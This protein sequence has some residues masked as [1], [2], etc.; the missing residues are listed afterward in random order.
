M[1]CMEEER[2]KA[3]VVFASTYEAAVNHLTLEQMGELFVKLGRYSLE[4]EAVH[5]E[6]PMVD[7]IL[8]MTIPNMD[9]AEERHLRAIENG[10]K[11][12]DFG[13]RGGRPRKGETREEYD[14]RRMERASAIENPQKPLNIDIDKDIDINKDNNTDIDKEI[15]ID[16]NRYK[17][18]NNNINKNTND[19]VN[20]NRVITNTLSSFENHKPEREET[21]QGEEPR[22]AASPQHQSPLDNTNK[23]ESETK[24]GAD[25]QLNTN[26]KPQSDF[27]RSISLDDDDDGV[28]P[29]PPDERYMNYVG[30][31]QDIVRYDAEPD[32]DAMTDEEIM[33]S[34]I[35][36]IDMAI[37][38]ERHEG[39][40]Q[41]YRDYLHRAKKMYMHQFR[42]SED[43]AKNEIKR[44]YRIRESALNP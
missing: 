40:T 1:V 41:R 42:C 23:E 39:I 29:C 17:E 36:T 16:N 37:E 21:H 3:F 25:P 44:R 13:N 4:G 6:T 8:K 7:V 43:E 14:A 19:I 33:Q 9:A 30:S 26:S 15:D 22:Q 5:S 28:P 12:K 18:I 20:S 38:C 32:Y 27:I 24:H 34:L 35:K 2:K 31:L 10:S 11:G